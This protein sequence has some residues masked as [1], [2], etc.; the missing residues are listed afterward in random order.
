MRTCGIVLAGGRSTRMGT[1]KA[2]LDWNGVPLL[3][4]TVNA[5]A[6]SCDG[7]VVVA[8]PAQAVQVTGAT[9]VRDQVGEQGPL[10]ALDDGLREAGRLGAG[11]AFVCATDMPLL[12]PAFITR[13]LASL[14]PDVDVVLPMANSREQPLAAGYSTIVAEVTAELLIGGERRLRALFAH[15]R[16]RRLGRAELLAD[17]ALAAA[18]PQ[19]HSLL[20]VNTPAQLA[21][22][23]ARAGHRPG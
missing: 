2:E 7:V 17:P 22:V 10:Q 14:T 6:L 20:N 16:V 19:L 23:R 13:V 1:P 9:V 3:Q 5:L 11:A 8:A 15:C 4:R 12:H 18:D 21:A